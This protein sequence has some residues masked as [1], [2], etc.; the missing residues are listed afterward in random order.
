[1]KMF[2]ILVVFLLLTPISIA[3]TKTII[4]DRGDSFVMED[5]N[6]TL[7]D[8]RK[9]DDKVLLCINDER[10]IL[11]EDKRI[12]EIYFEIKSFRDDG[13]KLI[14][15]GD[16][17]ECI[18]SDNAN[19]FLAKNLTKE[20]NYLVFEDEKNETFGNET[21]S[22]IENLTGNV[23]K[24]TMAKKENYNGLLKRIIAAVLGW[25]R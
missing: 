17:D 18:T 19:C 9:K 24:E 13:V 23:V 15:D 6:I 4:L 20:E 2:T 1:M 21:N 11:S 8:Y 7:M 12:G 14:L 25:P 5:I 16:C 3:R 10:E 22:E